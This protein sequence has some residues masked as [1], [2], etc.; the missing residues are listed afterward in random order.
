MHRWLRVWQA[1]HLIRLRMITSSCT[2][3]QLLREGLTHQCPI[4]PSQIVDMNLVVCCECS[5]VHIQRPFHIAKSPHYEHIF[6]YVARISKQILKVFVVMKCPRQRPQQS[7]W[8][9]IITS[10]EKTH[11]IQVQVNEKAFTRHHIHIAHT[12]HHLPVIKLLCVV[13]IISW[14]LNFDKCIVNYSSA[15]WK[16]RIQYRQTPPFYLITP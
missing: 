1:Y 16:M 3:H 4:L 7:R 15:T 6:A 13:G 11:K 2:N 12:I 10:W 8:W 9:R 14:P 5:R